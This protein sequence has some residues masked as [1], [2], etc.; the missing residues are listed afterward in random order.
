[1]VALLPRDTAGAMSE[2]NVELAHRAV[3]AFNQ[4]DLDAVLELMDADVEAIAP[5]V[6]MEGRYSGHA[7]IRRWYA[8]LIDTIPDVA[9]EV[10]EMRDFGGL[11]LAA[12]RLAGHGARS[13]T[14]TEIP[15]WILAEWRDRKAVRSKA[16]RTEAEALEAAGLEE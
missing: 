4:R 2:E 1:M 11:R 15:L 14:P 3:D 5:E 13:D 9:L 16:Y 12:L 8:G 7:G 6:E 10:V